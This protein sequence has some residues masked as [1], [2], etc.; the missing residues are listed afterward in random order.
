MFPCITTD[1][2]NLAIKNTN[3]L[4]AACLYI[5]YLNVPAVHSAEK[6][7]KE[8]GISVA[9]P[10]RLRSVRVHLQDKPQ[11]EGHRMRRNSDIAESEDSG[12]DYVP[13]EESKEEDN[14]SSSEEDTESSGEKEEGSKEGSAEEEEKEKGQSAKKEQVVSAGLVNLDWL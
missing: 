3:V 5:I 8:S 1:N 11:Q 10:E 12:S 2:I 13:E 14:S 6:I 4:H 7:L 9:P